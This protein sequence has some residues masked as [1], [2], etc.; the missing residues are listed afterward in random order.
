MTERPA[1]LLLLD[2]TPE[3]NVGDLALQAGL[4][5]LLRAHGLAGQLT[6]SVLLGP[7]QVDR[8]PRDYPT[9][10][11]DANIKIVPTPRPTFYNDYLGFRRV[12]AEA[13]NVAGLLLGTILL[14]VPSVAPRLASKLIPKSYRHT[15]EAIKDADVV[16]WKGKNFRAR[17]NRFLELYRIY[18][19]VLTPLLCHAL[20]KRI[21]CV[22]ASVWDINGLLS[23]RLLR[24][25]LCGCIHVSVR[26]S[27]SLA[28]VRKLMGD[29][30][31][32][33]SLVPDLSLALL[34]EQK[35]EYSS[36]LCT[37]G[38]TVSVT[39]VDWSEFG[40]EFRAKY[41]S[42]VARFLQGVIDEF[43]ARVFIVPQ[44][45]KKWESASRIVEDLLASLEEPARSAVEVIDEALSFEELL[46]QYRKSDLLVATRMHS[47]I[48]ALSVGT[49]VIAIPY[50]IGSK[51]QILGDLGAGDLIIEYDRVTAEEL[52][53]RYDMLIQRGDEIMRHVHKRLA[54]HFRRID[55]NI[56]PLLA[57]SR[58]GPAH[59]A[60]GVDEHDCLQ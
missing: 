27:E 38:V 36:D 22:G 19:K 15:L 3:S 47:A 17:S 59:E 43:G 10:S 9:L 44:V 37:R 18:S 39:L 30:N 5:K 4:I 52:R 60:R 57:N 7:N 46:D 34:S 54:D 2:F 8:I 49:P 58:G 56:A 24:Q 40:G 1:R 12:L 53:S 55:A 32:P 13:C 50:D 26:E 16:V 20:G 45:V 28:Q 33:I 21:I 6:V 23:R 31:T 11:L 25:A 42:S 48:F 35:F 14:A 41:V 29:D 51:W